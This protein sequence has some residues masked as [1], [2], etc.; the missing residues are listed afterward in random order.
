MEKGMVAQQMQV[1]EVDLNR[2]SKADSITLYTFIML[3]SSDSDMG[4]ALTVKEVSTL[5]NTDEFISNHTITIVW[6]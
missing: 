3:I 4:E 6:V 5:N 2:Y 1:I